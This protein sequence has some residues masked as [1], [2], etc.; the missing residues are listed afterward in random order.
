[1]FS[2]FHNFNCSVYNS[3]WSKCRF[4]SISNQGTKYKNPEFNIVKFRGSSSLINNKG[5]VMDSVH[6]CKSDR[7]LH[8]FFITGFTDG[9]GCFTVSISKDKR[10]KLGWALEP[11]FQI[12]LQDKDKPLL[13]KIKNHL[14][15]GN[16]TKQRIGI[17]QYRVSSVKDLEKIVDF[18]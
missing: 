11:I 18:F 2:I 6:F 10:R 12:G 15:V 17:F 5:L 8:P 9:E 1:M 13:E 4:Y 14:A 3:I 7:S 16:I